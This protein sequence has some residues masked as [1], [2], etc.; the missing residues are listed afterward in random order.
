VSKTGNQILDAVVSKVDDLL[1]DKVDLEQQIEDAFAAKK[2]LETGDGDGKSLEEIGAQIISLQDRLSETRGKILAFSEKL[3]FA[4][5][6][7]MSLRE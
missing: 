1:K 2:N 6:I 5:K 3:D 4:R 7:L